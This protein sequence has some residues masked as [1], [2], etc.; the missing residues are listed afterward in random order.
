MYFVA[1][2]PTMFL[3]RRVIL[4]YVVL[5]IRHRAGD[6]RSDA[7]NDTLIEHD[8]LY[9][10]VAFPQPNNEIEEYRIVDVNFP[11]YDLFSSE[12]VRV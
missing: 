1:D 8:I 3:R 7:Q 12:I 11:H 4:A 6:R 2:I 9:S 10:G 5:R